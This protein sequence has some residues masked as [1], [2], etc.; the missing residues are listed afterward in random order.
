MLARD[1]SDRATIL[2]LLFDK[3]LTNHNSSDIPVFE[4]DNTV[5]NIS[6]VSSFLQEYS[7]E[8]STTSEVNYGAYNPRQ[9]FVKR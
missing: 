3:W 4:A 2:D 9:H 5:T 8:E 6:S 1:P 7:V